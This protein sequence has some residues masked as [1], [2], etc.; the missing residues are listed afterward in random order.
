MIKDGKFVDQPAVRVDRRRHGVDG[1]DLARWA[2]V[3]YEG[4]RLRSVAA[5]DAARRRA[6]ASSGPKRSTGSA[7]SSG[8]PRSASTYGHSGF[9][10]GYLTEMLYFPEL[11]VA[12]AVQVNSSAPR[13]T[14]RALRAF[15]TEFAAI[16]AASR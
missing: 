12:I 10:P 16:V 9:F 15:L 13:S 7:S 4:T 3:L 6:G 2:K 5:A 1:E 8:R 11:K 14:G